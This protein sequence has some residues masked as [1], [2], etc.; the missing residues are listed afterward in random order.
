MEGIAGAKGAKGDHDTGRSTWALSREIE[1]VRGLW[2]LHRLRDPGA[3]ED[4]ISLPDDLAAHEVPSLLLLGLAENAVKH[5]PAAGH[6][7]RV[8][9]RVASAAGGLEILMENPG[10]YKG[11]R[12]G[13][14]GIDLT[15][16]RVRSH[17]GPN[18]QIEIS[19]VGGRT[20]ARLVLPPVRP[21]GAS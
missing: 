3:F 8:T 16:R 15:E 21:R 6:H 5:G 14:Q 10:P 1:L 9:L 11:P 2:E 4:E 18:A 12:V 13:G 19:D 7:G 17:Y 20:R